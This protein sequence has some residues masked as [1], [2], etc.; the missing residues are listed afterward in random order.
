MRAGWPKRWCCAGRA[1]VPSII[2]FH[3]DC[4][5]EALLRLDD[6]SHLIVTWHYSQSSRN[7]VAHHARRPRN[8]PRWPPSGTH[9]HRNHR[10]PNQL[11]VS[12]PRLIE[13][14]GLDLY[15]TD[16]DA[17]DRTQSSTS[18]PTSSRWD[19]AERFGN[20]TDLPKC[21]RTTG[22]TP[23]SDSPRQKRDSG[24]PLAGLSSAGVR[25]RLK[26]LRTPG[27]HYRTARVEDVRL[28]RVARHQA[29][30]E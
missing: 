25:I 13:I 18:A 30:L 2:R 23:T 14:K 3:P 16:L 4:P 7:D 5:P 19:L 27:A 28:H 1:A 15:V 12:F 6:F 11:A 21:S 24:W 29:P 9:A 20:S 10:R 26:D 8:D 17:V 22:P